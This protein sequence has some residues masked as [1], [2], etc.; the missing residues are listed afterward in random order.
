MFF[1]SLDLL[2]R[3]LF[4]GFA[5]YHFVHKAKDSYFN[6]MFKKKSDGRYPQTGSSH[7]FY[8]LIT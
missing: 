7:V 6:N 5:F 3:P 2:S 4:S 1:A 8:V